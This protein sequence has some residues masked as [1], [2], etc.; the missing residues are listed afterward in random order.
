MEKRNGITQIIDPNIDQGEM[1]HMLGEFGRRG[2]SLFLPNVEGQ[3]HTQVS[4]TR[5][6]DGLVDLHVAYATERSWPNYRPPTMN[7][8]KAL[9]KAI[10]KE[11]P[12]SE[13]LKP[14]ETIIN[15]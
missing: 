8:L 13:F 6:E 12:S 7:E 9:E 10:K 1:G 4:I 2:I 3:I 5:N 14:L 15:L 11:N